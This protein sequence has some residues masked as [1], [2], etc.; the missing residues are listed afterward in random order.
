MLL[1]QLMRSVLSSCLS[2]YNMYCFSG[3][4][5]KAT[6]IRAT[7]NNYLLEHSKDTA[8]ACLQKEHVKGHLSIL[9]P[10]SGQ[11]L[12]SASVAGYDLS[13]HFFS[14]EN[15]QDEGLSFLSFQEFIICYEPQ[16]FFPIYASLQPSFLPSF[17]N[18][19]PFLLYTLAIITEILGSKLPRNVVAG[20]NRCF[21]LIT[22]VSGWSPYF[23]PRTL[24][25]CSHLRVFK[26]ALL[27]LAMLPCLFKVGCLWDG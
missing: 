9:M 7:F 19:L 21:I 2:V 6:R 13:S 22:W 14:I 12:C 11:S 26:V 16:D 25:V 24:I 15:K 17:L 23:W 20:R 27:V 5:K 1:V 10:K 8:L 4:L 18:I 3:S